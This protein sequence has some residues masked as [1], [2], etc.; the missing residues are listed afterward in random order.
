MRP[1]TLAMYALLV[2]AANGSS[3]PTPPTPTSKSILNRL[4]ESLSERQT[5][6]RTIR[7]D[8]KFENGTEQ[9]EINIVDDTDENEE[10]GEDV[11]VPRFFRKRKAESKSE[12]AIETRQTGRK[13]EDATTI[14]DNSEDELA[15][16]DANDLKEG[17]VVDDSATTTKETFLNQKSDKKLFAGFFN[18]IFNEDE[19]LEKV[20]GASS[21][22]DDI[23]SNKEEA[24]AADEPNQGDDTDDNG[25]D[26][27][28]PGFFRKRKAESKS[29]TAI[30]TRQT[31]RKEEDATTISDNSEDELAI[32]DA[33]DLKEGSVVDDSATTT[34][35]TFLNQKSDKKLFAGFFNMIFNEDEALEK[36]TGASSQ[37]DD[38][39]SNKEEASAADEPNQD[40]LDKGAL[41]TE[42]LADPVDE[43][44]GKESH[45]E[46]EESI[47]SYYADVAGDDVDS[48][49]ME[50]KRAPFW[51]RKNVKKVQGYKD[52][53]TKDVD[54]EEP[55]IKNEI[56]N[57]TVGQESADSGI[58]E[59]PDNDGGEVSFYEELAVDED[60]IVQEI[61]KEDIPSSSLVDTNEKEID[62][63]DKGEDK[64][65]G[66]DSQCD[67]NPEDE[68]TQSEKISDECSGKEDVLAPTE[69]DELEGKDD[70]VCD[71]D[72]STKEGKNTTSVFRHSLEN[73]LPWL[74][75]KNKETQGRDGQQQNTSDEDIKSQ[76]PQDEGTLSS[77]QQISQGVMPFGGPSSPFVFLSPPPL[78]RNP[79]S[80]GAPRGMPPPSPNANLSGLLHAL[81]P[82]LSKLLIFTL[83]SSTSALFG[84]GE[85][86]VYSP[87]PSQHFMLERI[88]D[89]Y[90]KD[91]L[92][93]K[94]ALENP[95][96][97]L[98]KLSWKL[99]NNQRKSALKKKNIANLEKD[100][101]IATHLRPSDRYSRT[102]IILDVETHDRD[103]SNVVQQLR[104]SVSFILSQYHDTKLRLEMGDSLEI[105]VCIESPGGAVQEFGLAADQLSRLKEAG[106]IRND[107]T[108][109]VCVDKVAASGG[110]MMACQASKGQLLAAPFSIVGSI[111]V[112]TE[113]I[114]IHDVLEK[115][116]VKPVLLKAGDA[117][118]PLTQTTKVTDESIAIVQKNLEKVHDAFRKMVAKNRGEVI[119]FKWKLKR[120]SELQ[121]SNLDE[122]IQSAKNEPD[123]S[124]TSQFAPHDNDTSPSNPEHKIASEN[125][126]SVTN[127]DT[128]LGQEGLMNG[129]V[130]RLMT[131][132]EYVAERLGAGDRVLRLHKYDRSKSGFRLSPLDLLLLRSSGL[133]GQTLSSKLRHIV[134]VGQQ[135]MR[136]GTTM[137]I[138]KVLDASINVFKTSR[139]E[140]EKNI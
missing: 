128:F 7:S 66:K 114:N 103:M 102:V 10:N 28:V 93:M 61:E 104:D 75:K 21:Q 81:L 4:A 31:G 44:T 72:I 45:E 56:K 91:G 96:E 51:R 6:L 89:R 69:D 40:L 38:I 53:I 47:K 27:G 49:A 43:S 122:E 37:S 79:H 82:M 78:S 20:T 136:L 50:V 58:I 135:M 105:V 80:F 70:V 139:Q 65:E 18:M 98:S 71:S 14:S 1:H 126:N 52:K 85:G 87:E 60:H 57:D 34:K 26:V 25:E 62:T 140:P 11:G 124:S 33:N 84:I 76:T 123:R 68:E 138:I 23:E 107:L 101:E 90:G 94:K 29:E 8:Q 48:K 127:G 12:T 88:N 42:P 46:T 16:Q 32:Q 24:S 118:V 17:S 111:G 115:Y 55:I 3:S 120:K 113:T 74:G 19:A 133:V 67:G 112:L 106:S 63:S 109:T 73:A 36:V 92:A 132:D 64:G 59:E 15:I 97:Q 30:E 134:K 5:A 86:Q 54:Q 39:E 99:A 116:G 121:G 100:S 35:E 125:F 2:S 131:S 110:Y 95:P 129:L 13:E 119:Y 83:L 137:G 22:S 130:D 117:K 77:N 9:E 108:L 41:D